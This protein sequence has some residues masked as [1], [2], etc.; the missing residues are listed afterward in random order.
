MDQ[1][2]PPVD[3]DMTHVAARAIGLWGVYE[4]KVFPPFALSVLPIA[5]PHAYGDFHISIFFAPSALLRQL[6]SVSDNM[7]VN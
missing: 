7:C 3:A 4:L 5:I 6:S 2:V 1:P